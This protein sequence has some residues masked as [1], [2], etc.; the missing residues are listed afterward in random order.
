MTSKEDS[1]ALKTGLEN[2]GGLGDSLKRSME[3]EGKNTDGRE[4]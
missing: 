4:T 2:K 3:T 1:K